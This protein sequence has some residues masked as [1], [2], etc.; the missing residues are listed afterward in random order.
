LLTSIAAPEMLMSQIKQ[1]TVVSAN[2]I[3]PDI[4]TGLRG[5]ARLSIRRILRRKY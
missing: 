1:L 4:N 3:T 5:A 2:M